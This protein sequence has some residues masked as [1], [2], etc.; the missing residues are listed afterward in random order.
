[1]RATVCGKDLIVE[2]F[3]AE[4][5]TRHADRLQRLEFRFLQRTW[6]A[7]ESHLFGIFPAHVTIQ[8]VD[9]IMQ[10]LVADIRG[11]AL[12]RG[13]RVL[14]PRMLPPL[15]RRHATVE[16]V[17]FDQ[18]VEIDLDLRSVLIC[19]DFEVTEVTAFATKRDVDVEP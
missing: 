6:L 3:D 7:L 8:T 13:I 10:L 2:V 18:R 12:R 19:I 11:R 15:K 14:S 4:T 16:F 9:Q 17:L 5:N 1:M